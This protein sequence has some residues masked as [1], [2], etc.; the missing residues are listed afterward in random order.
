M[1]WGAICRKSLI[2][3]QKYEV[4]IGANGEKRN[5]TLENHGKSYYKLGSTM[6]F[7]D[8]GSAGHFARQT[9]VNRAGRQARSIV[10]PTRVSLS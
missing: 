1:N 9:Q 8:A 2:D 7:L 3:L 10:G 4:R 6:R 5:V